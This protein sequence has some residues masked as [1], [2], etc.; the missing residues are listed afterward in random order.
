MLIAVVDDDESVRRAMRRL[1]RAAN[2]EAETYASGT[3][4]MQAL[5]QR[6]PSCV[7]VDLHMPGMSGLEVQSRLV[8]SAAEIPIIFITAYDDPGARDRALLAG[9]AGYLRKPFSEEVLLK[10]I[11]A[12]VRVAAGERHN[13]QRGE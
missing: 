3:E 12:A 8:A 10:A 1:L 7:V 4:F 6:K 13:E 2:L 5:L 11:D 9:A